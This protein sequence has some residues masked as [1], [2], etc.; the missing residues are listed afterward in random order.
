MA[1]AAA[2]AGSVGAAL[3]S[4]ESTNVCAALIGCVTPNQFA[5]AKPICCGVPLVL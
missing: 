1:S 4:G 2:S 5:G 3:A